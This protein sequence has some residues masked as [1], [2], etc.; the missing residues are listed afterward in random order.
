MKGFWIIKSKKG[1]VTTL[2]VASLPIFA[3]LFMFIGSLAVAW[4]SHSNSQ[5]AGDAAS[6]A[7]THKID[8][9]VNAD[10]T[11]WLERYEG[12]YQKAI[13]SNAQRRAFIQWSIQRHRNEL[14]EVV[15]QYTRKHGAKG[16]GLITSRSGRVVVRAG[17]PF[18]S[19]IARN[20]FSKQDI[21]GDG[22]GPVRYYLKGLPNDTIHIEYNRGNR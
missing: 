11:L 19:M 8:G 15:K 18:Q 5:M 22:A 13:G 4:M 21:Q 20:Y 2:W 7:A 3:L 10:L 1:N 17:T 16:K 6:L 14:I 9:W 12:N